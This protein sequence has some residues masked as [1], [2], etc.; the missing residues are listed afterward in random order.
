MQTAVAARQADAVAGPRFADLRRRFTW[1]LLWPTLAVLSVVTLLPTLYLIAT[2]FT[3]LN[4]TLPGTA[5]NFSQPLVNYGLL[6]S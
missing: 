3:P 6:K 4:L 5:W 1:Y 2:S